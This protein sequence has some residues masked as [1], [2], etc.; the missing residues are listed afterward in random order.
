MENPCARKASR[1]RAALAVSWK[2]SSGFSQIF[3]LMAVQA[4][5]SRSTAASTAARAGSGVWDGAARAKRK[6]AGRPLL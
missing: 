2:A 4:G 1:I 3:R 6:I 5:A